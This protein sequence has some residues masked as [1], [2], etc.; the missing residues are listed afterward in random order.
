MVDV[1]ISQ[2]LHPPSPFVLHD[3]GDFGMGRASLSAFQVK[4]TIRIIG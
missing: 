4:P 3:T 1:G 2:N